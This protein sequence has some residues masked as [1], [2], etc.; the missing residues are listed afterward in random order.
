M[1][2]IDGKRKQQELSFQDLEQQELLAAKKN[3]TSLGMPVC[4]QIKV[5]RETGGGGEE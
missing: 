5:G 4:A 3:S 2:N 1:K